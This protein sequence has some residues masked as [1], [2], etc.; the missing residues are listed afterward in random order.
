[1]EFWKTLGEKLSSLS[2]TSRPKGEWKMV[3]RTLVQTL[4]PKD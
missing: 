3:V 4:M 1:M 2:K